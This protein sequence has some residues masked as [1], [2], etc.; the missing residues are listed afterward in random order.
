MTY[1]SDE[2]ASKASGRIADKQR[3]LR[4]PVHARPIKIE[5]IGAPNAIH[6]DRIMSLM[7]RS[8]A[9]DHAVLWAL[10]HGITRDP[11]AKDGNPRA[12]AKLAANSSLGRR[13]HVSRKRQ[14]R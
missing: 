10:V 12:Q 13:L 7:L 14:E 4:Q 5:S 3:A 11:F 2:T 6:A 1:S 9:E 8:L